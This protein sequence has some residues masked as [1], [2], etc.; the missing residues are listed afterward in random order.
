MPRVESNPSKAV[1]PQPIGG[2]W[3]VALAILLIAFNL[4]PAVASLSPVLS[5]VMATTGMT[6]SEASL[7]SMIQ[8]V[9]L[10][11]FAASVPWLVRRIG[12]ERAALLVIFAVTIGS[13]LRGLGSVPSLWLGGLIACAGIG[14]G[15]VL[16]PGLMKRDFADRIALMSGLYSMQICLGGTIPIGATAPLRNLFAGSWPWALEFWALPAV[17]SL[18]Y[19]A[20]LWRRAAG[21]EPV[22]SVAP[23][24]SLIRSPLAW[25][26]TLYM[27]LQS[28]L[29]YSAMSWLAPIMRSRGD[30]PVTAGFVASWALIV[31]VAISLFAPMLAARL[32]RQS[33]PAAVAICLTSSGFL[34][35]VYG[36]ISLQWVFASVMGTGM[37]GC[38][39]I[40]VLMMVMR[41]PNAAVAARLSA[42]AQ[43]GGYCLASF[44]PLLIGVVHDWTGDWSGAAAV[45]MFAGIVGGANGF[46]AGRPNLVKG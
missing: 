10:G 34:G 25:N 44:G 40:A 29:A 43:T 46:L 45:V 24:L 3:P 41:A 36:D 11:V 19:C 9:F 2:R 13:I 37:G 6:A 8:V 42:M 20:I 23:T 33:V 22:R 12:L 18:A 26:V 7:L 21:A 15:N 31:Q 39:G 17:L 5:E 30:D 28:A 14:A 27:G 35:L 4:R 16:M 38:F 1:T 32:K